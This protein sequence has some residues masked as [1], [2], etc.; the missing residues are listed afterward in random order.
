MALNIRE[1]KVAKIIE[2]LLR[3]ETFK[4]SLMSKKVSCQL[5]PSKSLQWLGNLL[6]MKIQC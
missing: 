5:T 1:V 6:L 2:G 3:K 4:I